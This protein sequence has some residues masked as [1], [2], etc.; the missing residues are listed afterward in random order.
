MS[1]TN[2]DYVIV[3]DVK[4]SSLTLSSPLVFYITDKNT[5][6]I[7]VRLVTKTNIG[8]GVDQYTDIE[9]ASGYVLLMRVIKPNDE[10]TNIKAT[11]REQESIFEFDLTE[12]FKDIPG[13]YICELMISTIVDSRQE[14]ITS[15]S[16]TYEVKRSV[17]SRID[18]II[19]HEGTTVE[20]LLNELDATKTE[21]SSQIQASDDKIENIKGELS[22]RLDAT[23]TELSSQINGNATQISIKADK[24]ELGY[25]VIDNLEGFDINDISICLNK[26]LSEGK[27]VK[28][29]EKVYYTSNTINLLDNSI[30][31]G[32]SFKSI[33]RLNEN[34]SKEI[35]SSKNKKNITL[36]N[37]KLIGNKYRNNYE[38]K[39]AIK[40]ENELTSDSRHIFKD[41]FIQG[42]HGVGFD[43]TGGGESQFDNI[44]IFDCADNGFNISTVD[45]WFN[46]IS[47]GGCDGIGVNINGNN[48]RFNNVKSWHCDYGM[49]IQGN[50]NNINCSEIQDVL[51]YG[52]KINGG[53]NNKINIL[54]DTVGARGETKIENGVA[55]ISNNSGRNKIVATVGDRKSYHP[56]GTLDYILETNSTWDDI[57]VI[58]SE[59]KKDVLTNV[60]V[61]KPTNTIKIFGVKNDNS[62]IKYENIIDIDVENTLVE[63]DVKKLVKLNR[64]VELFF[65]VNNNSMI[66]N[67]TNIVRLTREY[68]PF[69]DVTSIA[70]CKDNNNNT[71]GTC[72]AN[73]YTNGYVALWDI[74]ENTYKVNFNLSYMT[75]I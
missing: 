50:R 14:L 8:G 59:L 70:I 21:L 7:F 49:Y 28:L 54:I 1:N 74:P 40:I 9:D 56:E 29:L 46:N 27:T 23:K 39:P 61:V 16:F 36:K 6:N 12:N 5:S 68:Y 53:W 26:A 30:I 34:I 55:I 57:S 10:N 51:Y 71:V 18:Q 43:I 64:H 69:Y 48:N 44:Q 19:E 73:I 58:C 35:I 42:I 72:T 20:K 63:C 11:Q 37:F 13:T 38:K 66:T 31:L 47:V 25:H 41:I 2:R 45:N 32:C 75:K 33:I 62:Q 4:N 67:G 65:K 15:D 52:L 24:N 60:S 3:Y 22:S 17:L